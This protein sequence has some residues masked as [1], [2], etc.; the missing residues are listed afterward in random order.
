MDQTPQPTLAARTMPA[1]SILAIF[2]ALCATFLLAVRTVDSPDIGYHL[3]F[4]E[5][6]VQTAW[7]M[8]TSDY[9]Y[10]IDDSMEL[11]PGEWRDADGTFRFVNVNWLSQGLFYGVWCLGGWEGLSILAAV[12]VTA[13]AVLVIL[14]LLRCGL[15]PMFAAAVLLLGAI[16]STS[17]FELRPELLTF[18]LLAAMLNLLAKHFLNPRARLT[19]KTIFG[20]LALQV[21]LVNSHSFFLLGWALTGCL[22]GGSALRWFAAVSQQDDTTEPKRRSIA[23]GG[24]LGGQLAVSLINP[25]TWRTLIMPFEMILYLRANPLVSN[26]QPGDAVNP[27]S[28]IGELYHPFTEGVFLESPATYALAAVLALAAAGMLVALFRGRLALAASIALFAYITLSMR[29]NIAIG[30]L[31]LLPLSAVAL[32]QTREALRR[33]K[34]ATAALLVVGGITVGG[35]TVLA[36]KTVDQSYY[37][38]HRWGTRFGVG[39]NTLLQPVDLFKHVESLELRGRLWCD[40]NDSSSFWFFLS[41]HP[42]MPIV[43]NSWAWPHEVLSNSHEESFAPGGLKLVEQRY[44][45]DWIAIRT[46]NFS[47]TIARDLATSP[48]W[49]L[50]TIAPRHAVFARVNGA[51]RE[52]VKT[53]IESNKIDPFDLCD[54]LAEAAPKTD[55]KPAHALH[56]ASVS[57]LRLGLFSQ[58]CRMAGR[59]LELIENDDP[60][61]P[62]I[63][64]T[65]AISQTHLGKEA[66]Q[67]AGIKALDTGGKAETPPPSFSPLQKLKL[68]D[69]YTFQKELGRIQGDL[70]EL[71][72]TRLLE[73]LHGKNYRALSLLDRLDNP[74]LPAK[75]RAQLEQLFNELMEKGLREHRKAMEHVNMA[76]KLKPD[77]PEAK[78]FRADLASTLQSLEQ[79]R[80]SL[81]E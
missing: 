76:L 24:L 73:L 45:P 8:D 11:A 65:L 27:M 63:Y 46:D 18:L 26:A 30:G 55:P 44:R 23:L 61:A 62:H 69:H 36:W 70:L 1:L 16:T 47:E 59:A 48:H 17:R 25:W 41:P 29:R 78:R 42:D 4:G 68:V 43:T 14:L 35:S 3:G 75:D 22:L 37:Y 33:I 56:T 58:A 10:T 54:A 67:S 50:L 15:H 9:I 81:A 7:P 38:S 74:A 39:P 52:L 12:L 51:N 28:F 19:R 32:A 34:F 72:N 77:F 60:L 2:A 21:L 80:K 40:Y 49:Q 57:L 5:Q 71:S 6:L 66:F 13:T 64:F 31:M 79:L 53:L 20:I